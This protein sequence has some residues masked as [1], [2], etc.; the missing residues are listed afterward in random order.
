MESLGFEVL[1]KLKCKNLQYEVKFGDELS[2]FC[3]SKLYDDK[4][5]PQ[6]NS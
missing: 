6:K 3:Y 2:T 5:N 4:S 1:S